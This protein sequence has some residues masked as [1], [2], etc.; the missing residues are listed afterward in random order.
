MAH[1][2]GDPTPLVE[3]ARDM[4]RGDSCNVSKLT[5]SS[6]AGTHVD[7]PSHFLR[8]RTPIDRMPLDV[9]MGP[10]RV[11]AIKDPVHVTRE[12]LEP[13]RINR[14]ERILLKTRNS[15]RCWKGAAFRS[16]FVYLTHDAARLLAERRVRV[17]GVDYLSVGGYK[18]DGATTHRILLGAGVWIIEGLN[19]T[20]VKPGRYELACLPLRL[21]GLDGSPARAIVRPLSLS[22]RRR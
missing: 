5:L 14:G 7:A 9:A 2:P 22:R 3:K 6:H 18:K 16:D 15:P 20:R 13:H 12:E 21:E 8:G 4:D 19:L 11:I 10:A 17:V 1:W